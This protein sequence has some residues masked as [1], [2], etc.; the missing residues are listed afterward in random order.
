M[1]VVFIKEVKNLRKEKCLLK[2]NLQEIGKDIYKR[3]KFE[4]LKGRLYI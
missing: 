2:F 4:W 1:N 3:N